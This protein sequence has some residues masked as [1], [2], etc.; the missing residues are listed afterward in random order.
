MSANGLWLLKTAPGVRTENSGLLRPVIP[1]AP[2]VFIGSNQPSRGGSPADSLCRPKPACSSTSASAFQPT[3]S[4]SM[5]RSIRRRF[6]AST[7][8]AAR[9]STNTRLPKPN[10]WTGNSSSMKYVRGTQVGS[11]ELGS[12]RKNHRFRHLQVEWACSNV[13][14]FDTSPSRTDGHCRR[15]HYH[16][17]PVLLR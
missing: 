4:A 12:R 1:S 2:H 14:R 6:S 3:G 17:Q 5:S 10:V 15:Q 8:Y 9:A 16:R 13:S 11:Q 7:D